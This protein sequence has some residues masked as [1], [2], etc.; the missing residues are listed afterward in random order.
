MSTLLKQSEEKVWY[1]NKKPVK[2]GNL[3]DGQLNSIKQSIKKSKSN[4][5]GQSKEYWLNAIN[6]IL[7]AREIQNIN[8]IIIEIDKRRAIKVSNNL[9][10]ELHQIRLNKSIK[11]N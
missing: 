5:F 2:L 9:E 10:K 7:K 1:W 11:T 3:T 6:P 4:W 8:Q